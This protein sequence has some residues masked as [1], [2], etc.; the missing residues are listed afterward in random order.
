MILVK[1]K[2]SYWR[3][4]RHN[5]F[6]SYV[7]HDTRGNQLHVTIQLTIYWGE[8]MG[9]Q[10]W[11]IALSVVVATV[12]RV[13]LCTGRAHAKDAKGETEEEALP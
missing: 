1:T 3:V 13:E 4:E 9:A 5:N 8:D 12:W 2:H 10:I 11:V 6:L 7:T